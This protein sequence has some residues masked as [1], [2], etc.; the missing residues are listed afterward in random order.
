M[1]KTTQFKQLLQSNQLE[2]LLEAH[3]GISARIGQEAGFKG[4]WASGLCMSGQC[5]VRDSNEASWTQVLE[6]LEFMSDATTVPILLDGDT[7]YGN[8]NSMRRLVHKLE[9]RDVAAVCIED[10]LFPKTNSFI[11]G[12]TQPLADPEE[13]AGKIKAGKDAQRDKDF[14]I[15]ARVEAFIA[16]WGLGEALRRAHTYADA[17]ADAILIHSAKSVPDEVLAFRKAWD[18]K[19]PVVIVPTRYYSTPTDVYRDA[20]FSMVIWANHLLRSAV[21][22]MQR[23][24]ARI[25]T[26]QNLLAIEDEVVSVAE[27]FRLQG[28]EELAAAEQRYL[29]SKHVDTRAILLAAS[30]GHELGE[31]TEDKP[32]ALI[33]VNGR[34]LIQ[35]MVDAYNSIGVKDITVVRGYRK[36]AFDLPNLRYVD[37]DDYQ[38]TGEIASLKVALDALGKATDATLLVSYGDVMFG[39]FVPQLL[40]ESQADLTIVVDTDWRSTA[41]KTRDADLVRCSAPHSRRTFY[42]PVR[43]ER[44]TYEKP[45]GDFHGEWMGFLKISPKAQP[46]VRRKVDQLLKSSELRRA[47]MHVLMNSLIAEGHTIE[48]IYTTGHW[49]D[50]NSLTDVVKAGTFRTRSAAE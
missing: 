6:V 32:K 43:L 35:H 9:Q 8:F 24:A 49:L 30:R 19:T 28:A 12:E 26:D 44:M 50:V 7:G 36:E 21:G 25:A 13:F 14:C 23:T 20:G 16:G 39:K 47:Q 42:E 2:F 10:K 45:E 48:V 34:P 17:G 4:L 18:R 27:I 37:N 40:L 15:V 5:A 1:K 3:N 31:L 46:V 33:S 29:P 41:D 38:T 22:A 11:S